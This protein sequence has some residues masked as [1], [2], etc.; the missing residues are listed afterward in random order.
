MQNHESKGL[1]NNNCNTKSKI[2]KYYLDT[3]IWRDYFEDRTDK[4]RPLGE[5]AFRCIQRLIA[6]N[7]VII[8][9][10]LV[11]KELSKDYSMQEIEDMLSIC[12]DE[13]LMTIELTE[14]QTIEARSVSRGANIPLHDAMHA[15]MARDA[16]AILVTRD[17]HFIEIPFKVD[18]KKPEELI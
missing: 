18:I 4:F 8:I 1:T 6:E 12:T 7:A 2:Q 5:W 3:C 16:N 15:I 10:D 14:K 13:I 9:S 11:N 17:K